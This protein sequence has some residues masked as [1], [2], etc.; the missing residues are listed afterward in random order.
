MPPPAKRTR[1]ANHPGGGVLSSTTE[2][3]VVTLHEL[4]GGGP[5]GQAQP[6]TMTSCVHGANAIDEQPSGSDVYSNARV[7]VSDRRVIVT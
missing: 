6:P 5:V 7:K 2:D 3:C 1:N 4:A